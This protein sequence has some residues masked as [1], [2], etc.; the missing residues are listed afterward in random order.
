MPEK[1]ATKAERNARVDMVIQALDRKISEDHVVQLLIKQGL[2]YRQ[3]RRYL[4]LADEACRR[5]AL[6]TD[7]VEL[8]R[9]L[10]RAKQTAHM[11]NL[12]AIEAQ[13][14][15][16]G[17]ALRNSLAA[18][19][20]FMEMKKLCKSLKEETQQAQPKTQ[21]GT[22]TDDLQDIFRLFDPN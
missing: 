12:K 2:S 10:K 4:A 1:R 17:K 8:G 6:E 11:A 15:P 20:G 16:D 5:E 9:I 22:E 21:R 13:D 18:Q 7:P 3:G 19:K 14:N